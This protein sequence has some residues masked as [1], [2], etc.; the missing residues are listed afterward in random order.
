MVMVRVVATLCAIL[1]LSPPLAAAGDPAAGRDLAATWCGACHLVEGRLTTIDGAR[2]L[3]AV[4][5]DPK[6]TADRLH[7]FLVQPHGGMPG[8]SLSRR[9]IENLI[10]YIESL[11]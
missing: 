2:P 3:A 5:R 6:T 8:L 11:R 7:A 1:L 4:A 9:E 10:A